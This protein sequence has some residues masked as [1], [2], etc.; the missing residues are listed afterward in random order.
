MNVLQTIDLKKYYGSEPNVTRALDGVSL[1][2]EQGDRALITKP[3]GRIVGGGRQVRS[4][5]GMPSDEMP[6]NGSEGAQPCKGGG[7]S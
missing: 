7:R 3:V 5:S 1:S 4:T 6:P 2:V